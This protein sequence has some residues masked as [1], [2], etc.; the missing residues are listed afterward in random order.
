MMTT[1]D[2]IYGP[3]LRI[4]R[5]AS[6]FPT[7]C[8]IYEDARES[9]RGLADNGYLDPLGEGEYQITQKG[10][11]YLAIRPAAPPRVP[12]PQISDMPRPRRK[13][14]ATQK[15]RPQTMK[16]VLQSVRFNDLRYRQ[17]EMLRFIDRHVK[18]MGFPPTYREIGVE[19]GIPTV[20]VVLYNIAQLVAWGWLERV[21]GVPRSLRLAQDLPGKKT[22]NEI[23]YA[24]GVLKITLNLMAEPASV[25]AASQAAIE[26][27]QEA[28]AT[29][30]A[31]G[32]GA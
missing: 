9:A 15:P 25:I 26:R 14:V 11:D 19:V 12:K 23:Q 7:F 2:E 10:L 17:K 6:H 4:L 31:E 21:E 32:R 13:R 1:A 20:S 16:K 22:K 27:L 18:E 5:V 3:A 29:A 28:I 30:Q 8:P 24:R